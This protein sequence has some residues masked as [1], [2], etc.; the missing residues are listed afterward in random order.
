M[1]SFHRLFPAFAAALLAAASAAPAVAQSTQSKTLG[2][3]KPQGLILSRNELR[4]CLAQQG[5]IKT[6][7]QD[8]EQM[9]AQLEKEKED[10][11]QS[12]DG[13]RDRLATLD[14]TN[15]DLVDQYN[16][17]VAAQDKRIDAYKERTDTFN[18]QVDALNT[19][20]EAWGKNC[21]NRRYDE[22]DEL[23]IKMGK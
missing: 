1:S 10:I 9:R 16:A 20:R 22:K 11:K 4:E 18:A 12:A 2:T 14:R 17:D 21:E 8:A 7:R 15:K 23:A 19:D 3:G 5:R 13:M 6:K